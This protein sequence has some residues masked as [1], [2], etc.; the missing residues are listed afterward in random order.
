MHDVLTN[1]DQATPEW[2]TRTLKQAGC[3]VRGQVIALSKHPVPASSQVAHL[4]VRYSG[5]AP[6]SAPTR[7]VLK[8]A[9]PDLERRMPRRNQREIAFYRAVNDFGLELPAVRCYGAMYQRGELDQFQLLL[10]DPSATTHRAYAHS[11]VPPTLRQCELIIDTLA[12]VHGQ[13][14][15]RSFESTGI[16]GLH[17]AEAHTGPATERLISWAAETVPRFLDDLGE[18][19]SAERRGLYATIGLALPGRLVERHARA[20]DLTLTHGDVHIGNFLFPRAPDVGGVYIIDWK[21]AALGIGASDLAYMMALHW[22]PQVRARWERQLLS[23]Y[24]D[25][26]R[27]QGVE[28]NSWAA[29]WD[30]Y[31]LSVLRQFFEAV[32]GWSVRQNAGI[33]WNHLER[34]TLAIRNLECLELL[35]S[36]TPLS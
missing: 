19:L 14:W 26:L 25:A 33:W 13:C 3:L 23:R 32:W 9:D 12:R 34:I 27:R 7:L 35:S 29:L 11:V 36:S 5:D 28:R 21:R 15:N 8:L 17:P 20:T 31:R 1:L 2:L 16:D 10:E 18:R 22:F 30:D 6:D 24:Y 4:D